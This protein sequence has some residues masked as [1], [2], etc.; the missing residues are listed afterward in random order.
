MCGFR[1]LAKLPFSDQTWIP[2]G[3]K[4]G[5]FGATDRK[6][7]LEATE[8][9][10]I[11]PLG[12]FRIHATSLLDSN[13][14]RHNTVP[15]PP[16]PSCVYDILIQIFTVTQI[17]FEGTL[18]TRIGVGVQEICVRNGDF[19]HLTAPITVGNAARFGT[20]GS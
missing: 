10:F 15:P 14:E 18:L 7:G 8:V 17:S 5:P 13:L 20:G 4:K 19:L 16:P 11:L 1:V 3:P 2:C 9:C 6:N 12:V